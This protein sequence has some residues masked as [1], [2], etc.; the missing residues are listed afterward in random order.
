MLQLLERE[1]VVRDP[2]AR[3]S[4]VT[5]A[6][7]RVLLIGSDAAVRMPFGERRI[8]YA[9]HVASGRSL[10][11]IED[12]IVERTHRGQV[13][14]NNTRL[15]FSKQGNKR[16]LAMGKV[17]GA[18]DRVQHHTQ[19]QTA[20]DILGALIHPDLLESLKAKLPPH[21]ERLFPPGETLGVVPGAH[22]F[23]AYLDDPSDAGD[24]RTNQSA[25]VPSRVFPGS[26]GAPLMA[27][28]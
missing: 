11:W 15:F 18:S 22:A 13:M 16:R 24:R 27:P 5:P 10:R 25:R 8:V 20:L 12:F 7:V 14:Q 1:S 9:D 19:R 28:R 2:S 26:P 3:L 21:R 6:W 17:S 23:T 4:G